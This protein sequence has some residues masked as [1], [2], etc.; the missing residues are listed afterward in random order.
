MTSLKE[1]NAELKEKIEVITEKEAKTAEYANDM[2]SNVKTLSDK[3][4]DLLANND[5]L[6]NT[7][8]EYKKQVA[9]SD[10]QLSENVKTIVRTLSQRT[11]LDYPGLMAE[12]MMQM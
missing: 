5:Q 11:G 8:D 1:E 9:D 4:N 7:F 3:V 2:E 12:P 10:K 6:T